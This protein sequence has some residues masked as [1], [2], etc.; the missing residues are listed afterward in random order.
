M[1]AHVNKIDLYYEKSGSGRPLILLHG[2]GETHKIFQKAIAILEKQFTVYA[3]DSRGHGQ[4]QTVKEYHYI[5]IAEDI[6]CFIE[7]LHIESSV[8]YGFSD[9]GIVALL[10]A[11]SYPKLL[12]QIIISGANT[13]P[14]G[15]KMKWRLGALLKNIVVKDPLLQM[16][17][18]EPHITGEMLK[19]IVIPVAV[20]AGSHDVIKRKDTEYI[21]H[22]IPQSSL[23]ILE[24]EGHGT[25]IVNSS[26]IAK[27]IIKIEERTKK[28]VL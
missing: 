8:L 12:S 16:T 3:V 17:L 5:D 27:L 18:K 7:W 9:G 19:K 15:L 1:I 2:N 22:M 11:S 20:L 23:H 4:S 14:Q 25:Y 6:R 13:V 26:K 28:G 24:G 21:A 10:L